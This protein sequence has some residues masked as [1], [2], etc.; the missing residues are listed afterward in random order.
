MDE[1][2][3]REYGRLYCPNCKVDNSRAAIK[4]LNGFFSVQSLADSCNVAINSVYKWSRRDRRVLRKWGRT[5]FP[6]FVALE[7]YQRHK[8]IEEHLREKAQLEGREFRGF[9]K[10][11]KEIKEKFKSVSDLSWKTGE[12]IWNPRI[13]N[14]ISPTRL[15]DVEADKRK[16]VGG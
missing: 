3:L 10:A 8:A 5:L 6:P 2:Y 13:S 1:D 12:A 16:A 15:A 14:G 9:G 11:S 4:W 7:Y